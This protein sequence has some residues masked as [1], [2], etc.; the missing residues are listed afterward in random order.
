MSTPQ[1]H[2]FEDFESPKAGC[3]TA[4]FADSPS[5][6]PS[7]G[8]TGYG[9]PLFDSTEQPRSGQNTIG[10]QTPYMSAA[11]ATSMPS[12]MAS[13]VPAVQTIV[14]ADDSVAPPFVPPPI[15]VPPVH[16]DLKTSRIVVPGPIPHEDKNFRPYGPSQW[17]HILH[18]HNRLR[19]LSK[20][21]I[22][23]IK[24]HCEKLTAGSDVHV[25]VLVDNGPYTTNDARVVWKYCQAYIK[26]RDQVRNNNS[27]KKSRSRKDNEIKHWKLIALAAGATNTPFKFDEHDPANDNET[28]MS[29]ETHQAIMQM[30]QNW[31]YA[32]GVAQGQ[33]P[34]PPP[35]SV[36]TPLAHPLAQGHAVGPPAQTETLNPPQKRARGHPRHG[37]D[38]SGA[39]AAASMRNEPS[40][41]ETP[42]PTGLSTPTSFDGVKKAKLDGGNFGTSPLDQKNSYQ[43][44][45]NG[46]GGFHQEGLNPEVFYQGGSNQVGVNQSHVRH[47]TFGQGGFGQNGF[48]QNGFGQGGA[49][50][51][52]TK[53]WAEFKGEYQ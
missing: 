10:I 42:I 20:N 22:N 39:S 46:Q 16:V 5:G 13:N 26:R 11:M 51:D 49:D 34:P 50:Q 14:N 1:K 25:P 35:G 32:A 19:Y 7:Y 12:E 33:I 23:D 36:P 41:P 40:A 15:F 48:T 18:D 4:S 28:L 27:A 9:R 44:G 43:G 3:G 8:D 47:G 2:E 6:A 17:T 24:K 52:H 31:G 45:F 38:P 21:A 53:A 37:E 30:R 29:A